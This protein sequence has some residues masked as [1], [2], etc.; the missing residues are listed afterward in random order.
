MHGIPW[1]SRRKEDEMKNVYHTEA[2]IRPSLSIS[3]LIFLCT[4]S[5]QLS[6]LNTGALAA[7]FHISGGGGIWHND[8]S[9]SIQYKDDPAIDID[10]L[11]YDEENRPYGW[12]ELTHPVPVLPNLRLEYCKN[13]FSDRASI[14]FE[15][16]DVRFGADSYSK[17]ELKQLDMIAFYQPLSLNWI[18]LDLGLDVKYVK[19]T[20]SAEGSGYI[21]DTGLSLRTAYEI[22]EDNLFIPFPYAKIKF[23]VPNTGL[24]IEGEAKAIGYK[25]TSAYDLSIKASYFFKIKVIEL[26]IEAGYRFENLDLDQ[27][28]FNSINFDADIDLDGPF[29]GLALRF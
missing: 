12:F 9:G 1:Q 25:H 8:A 23:M 22:E 4:V 20:F 11:N 16:E 10:Y 27:D 21:P 19:F 7:D 15:W 5:I 14:A 13:K 24:E 18:A 26:G 28:D 3:V 29:A 2:T 17:M 6:T